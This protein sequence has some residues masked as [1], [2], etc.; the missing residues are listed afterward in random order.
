MFVNSPL[1]SSQLVAT[2]TAK[3]KT[4]EFSP[5]NLDLPFLSARQNEGPFLMM[6]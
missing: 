2:N 1:T 5:R 4:R 3:G 6:L